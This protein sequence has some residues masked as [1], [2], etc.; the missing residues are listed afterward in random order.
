[1][2]HGAITKEKRK[3]YVTIV[4]KATDKWAAWR[5]NPFLSLT[6]YIQLIEAF[7]WEPMKEYLHSF[8]DTAKWGAAPKTD[9]ET[10][11]Q[12]LVR[13]SKITKKNLGPFFDAWG[14]P[15]S[16]SAKAEVAKLEAWMPKDL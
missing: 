10:R 6:T 16:S 1:M 3:E 7:G 14:I 15:T 12:F 13:Y 4:K 11:D 8:A 2:G 5:S 9:E